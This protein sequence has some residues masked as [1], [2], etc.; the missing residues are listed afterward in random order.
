MTP[1]GQLNTEKM[2]AFSLCIWY[3]VPSITLSQGQMSFFLMTFALIEIFLCFLI[4]QSLGKNWH[5]PS[6]DFLKAFFVDNATGSYFN[7]SGHS[8]ADSNSYRTTK[9]NGQCIEKRTGKIFDKNVWHFKQRNEQKNIEKWGLGE[10]FVMLT[11]CTWLYKY[12]IN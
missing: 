10:V 8:H 9:K 3:R 2:P 6:L 4:I 11:K 5:N 1:V 7:Q 12:I